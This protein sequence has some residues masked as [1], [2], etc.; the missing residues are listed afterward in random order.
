MGRR[1]GADASPYFRIF[2]PITQ[3]E[4]FDKTGAYVRK[5]CPELKDLPDKYLHS[6]WKADEATLKKAGVELGKTYPRPIIEHSE[7]RE[8]ALKAWET[9]KNKQDAA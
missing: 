3:G 6:P 5:W 2:N 8:R 1:I 9:L 7:G 4:K